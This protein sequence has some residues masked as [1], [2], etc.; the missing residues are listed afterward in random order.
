MT[1]GAGTSPSAQRIESGRTGVV[2]MPDVQCRAPS[3]PVHFGACEAMLTKH[4]EERRCRSHCASPPRLR[5]S[6]R[7]TDYRCSC[8]QRATSA[9][10]PAARRSADYR[11]QFAFARQRVRWRLPRL[12]VAMACPPGFAQT[13]TMELSD[14]SSRPAAGP[15]PISMTRPGK[16]DHASNITIPCGR[17][18][19]ESL[20]ARRA[21][22]RDNPAHRR[23]WLTTGSPGTGTA[24]GSS[25]MNRPE[26][27]AKNLLARINENDY[28]LL[29]E[30][31]LLR[32]SPRRPSSSEPAWFF[33]FRV[34]PLRYW[35]P[36]CC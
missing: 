11:F 35:W 3:V 7:L 14:A 4:A 9:P 28:R 13:Q 16:R 25:P 33:S 32:F 30:T 29:I 22:G 17:S 5:A 31:I 12:I 34:M 23:P 8:L 26:Q 18:A 21:A 6:C 10:A 27:H 2:T 1:G 36:T 24:S 15:E 19:T 20:C